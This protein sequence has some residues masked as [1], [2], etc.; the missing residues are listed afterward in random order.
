MSE[1]EVIRSTTLGNGMKIIAW[2]M[3][4]IP[5]VAFCNWVRVGSRNEMPGRTGIAHFF[6]H[7]MFNGTSHRKQGE[8]DR[9]IEAQ[10][11][12]SN[13]FTDRD[14]TVYQAWFPREALELIFDLEA[15]RIANVTFD[16]D[17]IESERSVVYAERLLDVDGND[18]SYLTE[19]MR[20]AA[21]IVHPYR[22][23]IFGLPKDIQAWRLNDLQHFFKKYY[24]P[25][26]Q[27]CVLV[28]DV[29]PEE[30]FALAHKYL[31]PIPSG[32]LSEPM[33]TCEPEQ[34]T[35][36]RVVVRRDVEEPS[37]QYAY[38]APAATDERAFALRQLLSILVDGSTS[39]LHHVLVE[40]KKVVTG[41]GGSWDQTLDP[42]L[43]WLEF[44]FMKGV[45]PD[46]LQSLI[47]AELE[48]IASEQVTEEEL[49]RAKKLFEFSF[50]EGLET[51]DGKAHM[52][53]E[54]EVLHGDWRK[55]FD[56]PAQFE[57]VTAA[58]LRAVAVDVLNV[59]RRT[60]GVFLPEL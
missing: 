29:S 33:L 54:Y 37:I 39:R 45:D 52:L 43:L 2:P 32:A 21:F 38:K 16:P 10:G 3:H 41:V 7:M 48:R 34:I 8:F 6:E 25:N 22:F 44:T 15:D 36:R 9:L 23:P 60:V 12:S 30:V 53:G 19:Q 26:N 31:E 50:W 24:G 58:Q 42:G 1:R 27:T 46:V 56:V 57:R 59:N 55:L 14:F 51:I 13:A 11:G 35:E 18:N 28:G 40:E 17:V 47:D 20:A 49:R 5:C 4:H